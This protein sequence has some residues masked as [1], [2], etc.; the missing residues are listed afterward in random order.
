MIYLTCVLCFLLSL[1]ITPLVKK[2][3]FYIK[4]VDLPR[5]RK[6]H[7]QIMP[8]LGGL[9]IFLSFLFGVS[10]FQPDSPFLTGVLAGSFVIVFVGVLDDIYELTAKYKL[11]GQIIA[12]IAVVSGGLVIKFVNVPFVG[13]VET[14]YWGIPLTILWIILVINAINLIDGLDGLAAGISIIILSTIVFLSIANGMNFVVIIGLITIFSTLGFLVYNFHPAKIFMGDVGALF[15]GFVISVLSLLEFKNVTLLSL[16]VPSIIL[17]VP[18][19]DTF[20]AIIRRIYNKQSISQADKSH[21][22]HKVLR[23]GFTHLQT[24]LILYT[25]SLM[26]SAAAVMLSRASIWISILIIFMVLFFI[27]LMGEAFE[28]INKNYKPFLRL[29]SRITG[30]H[31]K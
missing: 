30:R 14:H 10:F 19:S 1:L 24:V 17:G 4:A 15:L 13:Q 28:L 31:Y 11:L 5:D 2:F 3:A 9:A 21:L 20:F 18:L 27:E 6:V 16:I 22:H 25:I 29:F 8:R 7:Q 12:S 23:M 26:F